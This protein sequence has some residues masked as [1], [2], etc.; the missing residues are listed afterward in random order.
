MIALASK[1]IEQGAPLTFMNHSTGHHAFELVDADAITVD[2]IDLAIEF[3]RRS[4]AASYQS[5]LRQRLPEAM[6][7]RKV[8]AGDFHGAAAAY[9]PLVASRP[10]DALLALAYGE[11]LLGDRQYAAAC[12]EFARLKD[13]GLGARDVGVPAARACAQSGDPAAAIAWLRSIPSQFM[14]ANLEKDSAFVAIADRP[15]FRALFRP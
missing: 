4:T 1:A 8:V 9:A 3:V 12:A 11:A 15:D 10:T 6:A 14:P 5:A 13:Q 2:I 7:S